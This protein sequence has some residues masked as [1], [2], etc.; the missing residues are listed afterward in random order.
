MNKFVDLCVFCIILSLIQVTYTEVLSDTEDV[1]SL[2]KR[3]PGWGKRSGQNNLDYLKSVLSDLSRLDIDK[4]DLDMVLQKRRPGWGKRSYEDEFEL[5]KRKPGWGKRNSFN[6]HSVKRA[7][8]WGKRDIEGETDFTEEE[9]LKR[10]PGWG[11]RSSFD[12]AEISK[13]RPGWG[14]RAPGW[15]KRS[16]SGNQM[17]QDTAETIRLLRLKLAQVIVF[18]ISFV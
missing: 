3:A 10:R 9:R 14:K 17:C 12:G 6:I 8:G 11:K 4:N 1:D 13:R 2:D 18:N 5:S 16:D 15:G 7:P